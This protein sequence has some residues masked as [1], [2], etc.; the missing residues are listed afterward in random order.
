MKITVITVCYN[1]VSTIEE[2]IL[3]VINQTYPA[4][5]YIVIDGASKDGTVD[6]IKKHADKIDVIVSE[7]DKGIYDAM[8]KGIALATG[9]YI[10]F[11]NAGD[12]FSSND[13]IEKVATQIDPESDIVYGDSVCV[14]PDGNKQFFAGETN[15]KMLAKRPIYRHNASFTRAALHKKVPFA[16]EKKKEFDYAL[17][18]NNIFTLWHNGSKFQK[19]D[20]CV[21]TYP[22]EGTSDRPIR[23]VILPFRVS[24]QFKRASLKEYIRFIIDL[25]L[26]VR[27]S[28]RRKL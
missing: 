4:I 16:L 11:M 1:V 13:A 27:Y 9:D 15:L 17:D 19:V 3:S 14:F 8:N 20:V 10:N 23:N 26:A 7:P 25:L 6:I 22:Q 24:H 2:T 12:I 28:I 18:Y 5:E 21:V